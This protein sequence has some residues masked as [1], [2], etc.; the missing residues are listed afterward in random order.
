MPGPDLSLPIEP[1]LP[2]AQEAL[3]SGVAAVLQTA[4]ANGIEQEDVIESVQVTRDLA[5]FWRT[6]YLDC[7][8]G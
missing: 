8:R 3:T 5:G 2:A 7:D 1:A 6:T 4:L